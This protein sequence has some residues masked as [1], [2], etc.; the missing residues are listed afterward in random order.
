SPLA[1][2]LKKEAADDVAALFGAVPV[3]YLTRLRTRMRVDHIDED[4]E[5]EPAADAGDVS[6]TVVAARSVNAECP[7]GAMSVAGGRS[8]PG[9]GVLLAL[10]VAFSA[11]PGSRRRRARR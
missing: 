3:P 2:A 5:L 9:A 4:R 7:A 1:A 10:A 6:R 11:R 8:A